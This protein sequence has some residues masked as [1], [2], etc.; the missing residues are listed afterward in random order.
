MADGFLRAGVGRYLQL[1]QKT[2]HVDPSAV[3]DVHLKLATS[4][5]TPAAIMA[6]PPHRTRSSL[7][8]P[9]RLKARKKGVRRVPDAPSP[10]LSAKG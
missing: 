4:P 2:S 9:A 1:P 7:H 10:G 5:S 8:P 6:T 3:L